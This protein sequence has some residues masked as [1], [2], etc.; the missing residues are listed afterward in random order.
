MS[1]SWGQPFPSDSVTIT[2]FV[3]V[4]PRTVY[5]VTRSGGD[6]GPIT[7]A[8]SG[9]RTVATCDTKEGAEAIQAL[10][11]ADLLRRAR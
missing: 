11:L 5:D 3:K 1:N 10:L 2:T 6:T 9:A 4:V 7:W 8:F